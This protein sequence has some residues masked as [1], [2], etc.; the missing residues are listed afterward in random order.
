M[1]GLHLV[2][3]AVGFVA[4]GVVVTV[5]PKVAAWFVKQVDSAESKVS[6]VETDA[7]AAVKTVTAVANTVSKVI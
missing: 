3:L 5:V 7:K 4:G 2:S 1:L 6:V